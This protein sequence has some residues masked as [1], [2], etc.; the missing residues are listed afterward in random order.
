MSVFELTEEAPTR[1]L[2]ATIPVL[3]KPV[4]IDID[5]NAISFTSDEQTMA[6]NLMDKVLPGLSRE[7]YMNFIRGEKD[8]EQAAFSRMSA[9]KKKL[10]PAYFMLLDKM[11]ELKRHMLKV[12]TEVLNA[13]QSKIKESVMAKGSDNEKNTTRKK[14]YLAI[15][16]FIGKSISSAIFDGKNKTAKH[17]GLTFI[18]VYNN[19]ALEKERNKLLGGKKG[20]KS[21][22]RNAETY[23]RSVFSGEFIQMLKESVNTTIEEHVPDMQ[24]LCKYIKAYNNCYNLLNKKVVSEGKVKE[25]LNQVKN[26]NNPTKME[27]LG[28][29]KVMDDEDDD[30]DPEDNDEGDYI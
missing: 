1:S 12:Y 2:E 23:L 4:E 19:D 15:L 22:R 6:D 13:L 5:S 18:K 26:L 10:E 16:F 25:I 14:I 8:I 9:N 20:K 17:R 11:H 30:Y 28:S 3:E 7:V 27:V 24:S 21:I 29:S